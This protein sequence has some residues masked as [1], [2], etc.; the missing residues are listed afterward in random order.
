VR[1]RWG[2]I[3]VV[4]VV[5]VVAVVVVVVNIMSASWGSFIGCS[6]CGGAAAKGGPVAVVR[7]EATLR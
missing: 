5:A 1:Q 2:V 7:A 6:C 4:V 3:V